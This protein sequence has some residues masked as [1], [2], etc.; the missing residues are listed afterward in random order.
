MPFLDLAP[1]VP[2][3]PPILFEEVLADL[4]GSDLENLQRCSG[5]RLRLATLSLQDHRTYLS[6]LCALAQVPKGTK[7][8]KEFRYD[9]Y[10]I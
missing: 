3:S 1:P 5:F 10:I 6:M 9:I 7:L 8:K 4:G 2:L